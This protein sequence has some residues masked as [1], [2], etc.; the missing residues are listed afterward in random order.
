[1]CKTEAI[2]SQTAC[3][4]SVVSVNHRLTFIKP[5]LQPLKQRKPLP[6]RS[7]AKMPWKN[8]HQIFVGISVGNEDAGGQPL[9]LCPPDQTGLRT[10]LGLL[11]SL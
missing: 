4:V 8:N 7:N 5:K 11:S 1:M 2:T 3:L 9:P 6:V 10:S